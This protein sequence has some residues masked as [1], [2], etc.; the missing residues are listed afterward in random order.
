MG[1]VSRVEAAIMA[2]QESLVKKDMNVGAGDR[3]LQD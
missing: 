2:V 3:Y 1:V